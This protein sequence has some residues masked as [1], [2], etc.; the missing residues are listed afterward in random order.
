[1]AT[2]ESAEGRAINRRIA[3]RLLPAEKPAPAVNPP[4]SE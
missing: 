4:A 1:V 2:N 3:I